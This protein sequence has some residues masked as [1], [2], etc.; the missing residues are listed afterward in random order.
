MANKK[1]FQKLLK[2]YTDYN[3]KRHEMIKEASDALKKS[4][5]AIFSLHRGNTKE[6]GT[7]LEETESIFKKL[8]RWIKKEEGLKYEGVYRA[9]LEEYVEGQMFYNFL[10]GEKIDFIN[11][12]EIG[13]EEY[14]SGLCD[15]TG[16][17][18]RKAVV[19]VTEGKRE[20]IIRY[21]KVMEQIIEEL[22]KFDLVGKLRQKYDE[23]KRNLKRMEEIFYDIKIRK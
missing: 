13:Y 11:D 18:V 15:F 8:K 4:K 5:Q 21:K 14:L 9:A 22:I 10:K 17:L 6:A 1:L 7:L 12:I 23:A 20:E 3:E 2:D 16:E 19:L